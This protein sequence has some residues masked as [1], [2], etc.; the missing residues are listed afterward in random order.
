[1]REENQPPRRGKGWAAGLY[2][3]PSVSRATPAISLQTHTQNLVVSLVSQFQLLRLDNKNRS[4]GCGE[5]IRHQSTSPQAGN[6]SGRGL[7]KRIMARHPNRKAD[8]KFGLTG[9]EGYPVVP[10]IFR[11]TMV[12]LFLWRILLSRIN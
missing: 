12:R 11:D 4:P 10:S 5:G 8:A 1:M 6:G 2:V 9:D 3:A 7:E